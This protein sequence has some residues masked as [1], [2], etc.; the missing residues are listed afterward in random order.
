MPMIQKKQEAGFHPPANSAK[1]T[2][3]PGKMHF[4]LKNSR[5]RLEIS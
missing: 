1:M 3:S 4:T 5:K 2:L